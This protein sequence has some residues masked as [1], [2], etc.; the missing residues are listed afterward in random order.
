MLGKAA[1]NNLS[2]VVK[3]AAGS[4]GAVKDLSIGTTAL[5]G[6]VKPGSPSVAGTFAKDLV[7]GG[8]ATLYRDIMTPPSL[9][10]RSETQKWLERSV[11]GVEVGGGVALNLAAGKELQA[12]II[13]KAGIEAAE[14]VAEKAGVKAA[15]KAGAKSVL[16]KIPG[17]AW[18]PGGIFALGRVGDAVASGIKG[19]FAGAG[20]HLGAA[21]GEV[22]SGVAGSFPGL[23]TAVSVA[24]DIGLGAY[25]VKMAKR[26]AEMEATRRAALTPAQRQ[27][28]DKA[29]QTNAIKKQKELEELE[30]LRR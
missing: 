29:A 22:A 19:D 15:E 20:M 5:V 2:D 7:Q 13:E 11:A 1:K 30:Y 3:L 18:I 26:E 28:E 25:D 27:A 10:K 4:E 12:R 17:L 16:K 24:G 9:D 21:G 6:T 8:A 14:K 23:G